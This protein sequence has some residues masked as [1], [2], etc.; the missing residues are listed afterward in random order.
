MASPRSR[1]RRYEHFAARDQLADVCWSGCSP[2]SRL[3]STGRA[4]EP[5]GAEVEKDAR[6]TS[7]PAVS[8][9]VRA[10]APATALWA[11]MSRPLDG[12]APGGDDARRDR[13][14]TTARHVVAL[15]ISTEGVKI[16]LGLWEGSTENATVASALL[17]DL[18]DRG[19]DGRAGDPVRDRRRRRRFEC[20]REL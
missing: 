19:L 14:R 2:A 16:P 20:S 11:L 8:Q 4:Q 13:A 9:D 1:S 12:S 3:A 10:S 6:S 15:G 7:K 5:V 17:A 18:V